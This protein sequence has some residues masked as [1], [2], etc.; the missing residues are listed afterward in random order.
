LSCR[1][2]RFQAPSYLVVIEL[3][4]DQMAELANM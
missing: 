2:D 1:S 3:G 4:K